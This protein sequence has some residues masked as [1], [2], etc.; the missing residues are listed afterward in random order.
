[1]SAKELLT[2]DSFEGL[3]AVLARHR[4][5]DPPLVIVNGQHNTAARFLARLRAARGLCTDFDGTLHPGN[6]WAGLRSLQTPENVA[7]EAR[8][9]QAYLS[10]DDHDDR[11]DVRFILRSIVRLRG[12]SNSGIHSL[13]P[14]LPPRPGAVELL[15]GFEPRNVAVV[16]FGV[17]DLIR[18]W[19]IYYRAR[20]DWSQVTILAVQL[21]WKRSPEGYVIDGCL[22]ATVVSNGNKG[23]V[24]DVFCA[25]RE[26]D[27]GELLALGDAP[28]DVL[29]MHPENVGV[30]IVPKV[31]P[32]PERLAYRMRGLQ[33]LWSRVSAVYV[34]DTSGSI[35]LLNE[36][37]QS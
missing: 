10:R 11:E 21:A 30:L 31:D 29:M 24:R 20:R 5:D 14:R 22:P 26:I 4:P 13:M 1:M 27:P 33:R 34:T 17:A 7:I 23:F 32:E 25:D 6:Q 37:R 9:L 19:L 2:V 36:L 18:Q 16:S 15:C 35:N 12:I 8:E 28:T 3:M